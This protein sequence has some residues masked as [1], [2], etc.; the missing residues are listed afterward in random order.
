MM[1]TAFLPRGTRIF[2]MALGG[3][4]IAA[5]A[6]LAAAGAQDKYDL[7]S[8]VQDQI[9]RYVYFTVFDDINIEIADDHVVTLT[10]SVTGSH[11]RADI[12]KRVAALDGVTAVNNEIEV[13]PPSSRDN[14]LRYRIARAIYGNPHFWR[15]G[16]S[17]NP[18]IHIVVSRGH[19][20]LTGVVSNEV[21]RSLARSLAA[22]FNT[23]SLTNELRLPAEVTEELEQLD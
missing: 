5:T 2:C 18:P 14:R 6:P 12:E 8:D 16:T 15:H 17:P 11:K 3:A 22:Q 20:R 10:G 4:L 23:F 19:V 1:T 9:L 13:L 7:F 21:D